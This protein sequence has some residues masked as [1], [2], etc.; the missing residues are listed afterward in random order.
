[1]VRYARNPDEAV[2]AKTCKTR[3][4][5]LRVHYKNTRETVHAIKGMTLKRAQAF[6]ENVKAKKEIVPFKRYNGSIGRK[7]QCKAWGWSQGRWPT[8]S[9][10]FVLGLLKNAES[11]AEAK[12][13]D[14]EKLVIEHGQVNRAPHMRRR[15]YRAHGRINPYQSSPCHVEMWLVERDE[16]VPAAQDSTGRSKKVVSA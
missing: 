5:Y 16:T 6:L 15:T 14:T 1:M 11:N 7:A 13:L 4:S 8:K 9:A 3:G 12:N 2:E 10:E